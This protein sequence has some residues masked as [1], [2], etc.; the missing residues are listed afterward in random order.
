MEP[1]TKDPFIEDDEH[2]DEQPY[3][4]EQ[5][6]AEVERYRSIVLSACSSL[7]NLV[8]VAKPAGQAGQADQT[9]ADNYTMEYVPKD[10]CLAS[11]KDIKRYIQMDE[12]GEGKWVLQWL[13]EWEVLKSDI[14]PIFTLSVKRLV[15]KKDEE[16]LS[17]DDREHLLKLV[18]I[19]VELFVFM[20]WNM[21]TESEEVKVRFTRILRSYKRTFAETQVIACL[22]SVAVMH[23]RKNHPSERE[24]M[25]IKGVLYVFRNILA[26]PDPL[27]SPT[28][29]HLSNLES[30]DKLLL[31]MEKELVIDFFLTMLSCADERRFKDLRPI[32]LDTIY[33]VYYRVPVSLLFEDSGKWFEQSDLKRG[34]R[35][36][37][38]GGIYALSTSENTVMPVFNAREVLKPFANLFRKQ[39]AVMEP[40]KLAECPVDYAWR[41]VDPDVI[42]IL[43]RTAAVFIESCFN[44]FF[45]AM[46][47]DLKVT[48]S[49][50]NET[51]PR[52]LYIAGYFI[53]I[54]LANSAIDLGCI[55]A[56]VQTHIFGLVMR[57]TST[58]MELK[59]WPSLEPSMYCIQQIM[60]ALLKMRDTK[61]ESLS[62]NVLSN[63]FYDG[64]ALDLFVNLCRASKPTKMR[65]QCLE[66]IARLADTFLRTLK[67][68]SETRPGLFVK[69]RVKRRVK[70]QTPND[71]SEKTDSDDD[72]EKTG[73]DG[74]TQQS[75]AAGSDEEM[76]SAE[77]NTQDSPAEAAYEELQVERAF[78]FSKYENAFAVAQVVVSFSNLLVPPTGIE[79]VYPMLYRIAVTCKKPHLFFKKRILQRLLLMFNDDLAI[80]HRVEMLDL[81]CWIFRQYMVVI[82]SPVLRNMYKPDSLNNQLA[83]EC[84][85]TFLSHSK[86]GTSIE[87]VI[88]RRILKDL[89]AEDNDDVKPLNSDDKDTA[90]GADNQAANSAVNNFAENDGFMDDLDDDFDL[91]QMLNS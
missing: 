16:E 22:L 24:T 13:G 68:Y 11:L 51:I 71:D 12:Q 38:F 39:A 32:L 86:L 79:Y 59:E 9:T 70:K 52:L 65:R 30:Q 10:D 47:D 61:L 66:Q 73:P 46:F 25:L 62:E 87:P 42:P 74:A 27:V 89:A 37:N 67:A 77:E 88:S 45:I 31:I 41:S 55:S 15:P 28:S 91:D 83:T 56:L 44:P 75:D 78:A 48:T 50:V 80:P 53:D 43:R 23:L 18:M 72:N 29:V 17:E 57:F 14:I 82:N 33:Y 84:L 1:H 21:K 3:S 54:S 69:K 34:N 64:D 40:R 58:Y 85:L 2:A 36:A 6:A 20:T 4:D 76:A 26:I 63:L 7:G 19:C 60:L 49:V 90:N 35:H 8:Q 5:I 81:V